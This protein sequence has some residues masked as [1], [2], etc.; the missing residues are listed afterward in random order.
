MIPYCNYSGIGIIPWAPVAGEVLTRPVGTGDSARQNFVKGTPYDHNL[1]EG[2]KSIIARV[3]EIS[4]KRGKSMVQVA[5]AWVG[6]KV[7]SP[8]VAITTIPRVEENIITEFEL[9]EEEIKYLEEP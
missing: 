6:S 2:D 1:T 8:V 5:L 3:E 4:K 9:T 7:S